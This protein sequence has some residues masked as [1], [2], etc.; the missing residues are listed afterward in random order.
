MKKRKFEI[1]MMGFLWGMVFLGVFLPQVPVLNKI[2]VVTTC[3]L[4]SI[5]WY[6]FWRKEDENLY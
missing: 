6:I 3:S 2:V 4:A 1:F 5:I